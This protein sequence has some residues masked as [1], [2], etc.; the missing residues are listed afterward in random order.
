M[1]DEAIIQSCRIDEV[2]EYR[3]Q[4]SLMFRSKMRNK[5]AALYK[6]P[7]FKLDRTTKNSAK[8]EH[9]KRRWRTKQGQFN[10]A[11]QV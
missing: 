5:R 4:R 9:A 10:F 2:F 11:G 1:I 3:R 6:N 7:F 8:S